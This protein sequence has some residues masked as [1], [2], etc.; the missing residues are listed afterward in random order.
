MDKL[1]EALEQLGSPRVA[2]VGDY[3]LD[4]YVYGDVERIS[5]EAP[6][7]V[8]KVLRREHRMGGAG[9]VAASVL[10]LGGAA[11][12]VG[13]V[14]RDEAGERLKRLLSESGAR[15]DGLVRAAGRTTT[16]KARHIGLAQHRHQQ[17]ILRVDEE[18]VEPVSRP[19]QAELRK[20]LVKEL[21]RCD[22]VAIEDY[23]KGALGEQN[24]PELIADARKAGKPVL[25]D[26]ALVADYRRYVG[27]TVLTPNRYEAQIASGVQITDDDSLARA[28]GKIADTAGAEAVVIK[29]DREG[30]YLYHDG[31][32]RRVPTR[33]R[34]VYDVTGAGDVVLAMLAIALGGGCGYEAAAALANVVGGLEV[35]R[36]GVAPVYRD[37]VLQELRGMI[38]LRGGKVVDRQ[39]LKREVDRRRGCGETIV[40]TNGCFDLLHMGHLRYLRQARE[41]GSCLIVAV[42]SDGSTHRLK[43][44]S[45]PVIGQDE[46][47]EMVA[48]LECVDYVTIFDEDT[49][50]PLL[51]LLRP[52]LLVKGGS[53]PVVVG[54]QIVEACGG[55][56]VTLGLV[57]GLST[58]KIINRILDSSAGR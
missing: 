49:P 31:A 35:S 52:E 4:C 5:P 58:T 23:D 57:E 30:S 53:T 42:N 22:V 21:P 29:L 45:R 8:L 9:N 14:G 18:V 54:R 44:A 50:E 34:A 43:G 15:T 36:F 6:V 32:G 11:S 24:T 46:R 19:R 2:V 7:P 10:A 40:F 56:V 26:P 3:M 28:A 16:I 20:A 47:A 13:M 51:E 17:Q 12:C 48:A 33:S 27:A 37:E 39:T 55:R 38:G 41:L 25:V 1:I